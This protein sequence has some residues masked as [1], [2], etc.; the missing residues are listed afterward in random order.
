MSSDFYTDV[1]Q[2]TGGPV[3]EDSPESARSLCTEG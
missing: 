3:Y 1:Y 2:P